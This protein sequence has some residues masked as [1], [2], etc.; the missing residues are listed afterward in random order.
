MRAIKI[1]LFS[2]LAA[3]IAAVVALIITSNV[4]RGP[5]HTFRL[6]PTVSATQLAARRATQPPSCGAC[7]ASG[8]PTRSHGS[9]GTRSRSPC[10]GP[11]RR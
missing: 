2:V 7:R 6:V 5:A 10:T 11:N 1:M 8:T 9:W 3:T 4:E